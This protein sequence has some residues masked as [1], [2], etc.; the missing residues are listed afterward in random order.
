[1]YLFGQACAEAV[2]VG[3][4]GIPPLGLHKDLVAV[5]VSKAIDLVLDT[6]AIPWSDAPDAAIEHWAAVETR[7]QNFVY[8]GAR[9]GHP[10]TKLSRGRS[11]SRGVAEL[12]R[13][14]I[15][16]LFFQHAVIDAASIHPG[17]SPGLHATGLKAQGNE[18]FRNAVAG[19]FPGPSASELSLTYV[20]NAVHEGA[21]GKHYR[22]TLNG[23]THSHLDT[24]HDLFLDQNALHAIL[25]KVDVRRLLQHATPFGSEEVSVVLGPRA[26][27]GGALAPVQHAELN[28]ASVAHDP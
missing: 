13:V 4:H 5:L 9:V 14:L 26:P 2:D 27:H 17:W 7:P 21:A 28:G 6:W 10:T 12:A 8:F 25:P 3:L 19:L 23:H 1:M 22:A 16:R 15:A 20:H 24:Y 18:L 11:S